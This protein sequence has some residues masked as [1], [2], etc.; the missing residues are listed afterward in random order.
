MARLIPNQLEEE[1][2]C[3]PRC[4]KVNI[5]KEL[6]ETP[7]S[8]PRRTQSSFQEEPP[9]T[10]RCARMTAA[11]QYQETPPCTPRHK[12]ISL[13]V[14]CE[15]TPPP[16]TAQKNSGVLEEEITDAIDLNCMPALT[17]ALNRQI[18]STG[19]VVHACIGGGHAS[20]L[21]FVLQQGM[22][23]DLNKP[24]TCNGKRPLEFAIGQNQS[25]E[26]IDMLLAHGADP[27]ATAST[28]GGQRLLHKACESLNVSA[29]K[30]LLRYGAD[31]CHIDDSS[32]TPLHSV[33]KVASLFAFPPPCYRAIA[34]ALVSHGAD[35]MHRDLAGQ[36]AEDYAPPVRPIPQLYWDIDSIRKKKVVG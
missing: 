22:Q 24:S 17:L 5:L 36:L 31:P 33:C 20:A 2:P 21:K 27:N 19:S 18:L 12:K 3:T 10:P 30:L 6:Q 28:G 1:P 13:E 29:V 26:I 4:T 11:N 15:G 9:C 35:Q 8:T 14:A 34:D 32:C 16:L 7:P 23:S 25:D